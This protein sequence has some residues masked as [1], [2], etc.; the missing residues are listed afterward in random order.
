MPPQ[1][2][3]LDGHKV[4][5]AAKGVTVPGAQQVLAKEGMPLHE[6]PHRH[7]SLHVAYT[8]AFPRQLT[9]AQKDAVRKLFAGEH[10]EL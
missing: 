9:Q 10:D 2:E 4:T 8:V 7:G 5:L 6:H 3:H 1:I